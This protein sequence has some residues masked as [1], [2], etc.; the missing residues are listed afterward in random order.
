MSLAIGSPL[1]ASRLSTPPSR[2]G[3]G[4]GQSTGLVVERERLQQMHKARATRE[5]ERGEKTIR[6]HVKVD[7]RFEK[8]DREISDDVSG[9]RLEMGKRSDA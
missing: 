4:E 7:A 1:P 3:Y 2:I 6:A 9:A 8:E 5:L